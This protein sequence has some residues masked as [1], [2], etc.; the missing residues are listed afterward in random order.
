MQLPI[1]SSGDTALAAEALDVSPHDEKCLIYHR[2]VIQPTQD[3][4]YVRYGVHW[5]PQVDKAEDENE[6]MRP[7]HHK[8]SLSVK[9][10][11]NM[12]RSSC[13]PTL[14]MSMTLITCHANMSTFARFTNSLMPSIVM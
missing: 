1:M 5:S 2:N 14:S 10:A 12:S 11:I 9:L 7:R 6:D 4:D 13:T 8:R 3:G